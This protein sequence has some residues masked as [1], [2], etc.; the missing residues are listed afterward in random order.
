MEN[1][2]TSTS[3]EVLLGRP[4][5]STSHTKIDANNGILT[6]E[7]DGEVV[8]FDVYKAMKYPDR[9]ESINF[10]GDIKPLVGDYVETN[11]SD[12]LCREL[13]KKSRS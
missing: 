5:L 10:V 11:F 12:D 8:K 6:M 3:P 13:E 9:V 1:D 7:F 2:R 4:F